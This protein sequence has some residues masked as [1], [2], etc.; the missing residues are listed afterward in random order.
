MTVIITGP[1]KCGGSLLMSVLTNLG[2]DTGFPKSKVQGDVGGNYEWPL[3]GSRMKTPFPHIVKEPQMCT[4]IDLRIK[5]LNLEVDHIYIL[6]RRPGPIAPALEFMRR[7]SGNKD[8]FEEGLN[9]DDLDR[10]ERG[11]AKRIEQVVHLIAEL[12]FPHTLLSYPRFAADYEY[13]Y[14]KLSHLM[15]QYNI[16]YDKFCEVM[17]ANVDRKLVREAYASMPEWVRAYM[18]ETYTFRKRL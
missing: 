16:P 11:I 5:K 14:S 6:L 12:D 9:G 15:N 2:M 10:V 17:G 1:G 3:R 13:A 4:D 8:V 18:R 7:E